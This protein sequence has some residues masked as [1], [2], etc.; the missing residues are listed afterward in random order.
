MK[1]RIKLRTDGTSVHVFFL[2]FS[3]NDDT[4]LEVTQAIS[5]GGQATS[6]FQESDPVLLERKCK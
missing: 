2:L 4:N 5:N 3:F 6:T 1:P